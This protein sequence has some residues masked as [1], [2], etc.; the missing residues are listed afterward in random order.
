MATTA[1]LEYLIKVND[2]D[3]KELKSRVKETNQALGDETQ[4]SSSKFGTAMGSIAKG[5]AFAAGGAAIGGLAVAAKAGFGEFVEGQKVAAQTGAVLKSTGGAANV[6]A[7][8][9]EALAGTIS[10]KSGIDD[11]AIQ[12]GQNLLLTF[13]GI[14]N[15]AGKGNDIFN[16]AT[17][18]MTDMSVAMGTDASSQAIQLGKALNDPVK[19]ISA[20]T[21]V[22][23]TFTDAQK[24]QIKAMQEA[25]NTAG[26]QKVILAELQKEFGGSAEAAG[27][28]FGGQLNI[29]K[30]SLEGVA[31]E[32]IGKL[33]P[34]L[35]TFVGYL[36]NRVIPWLSNLKDNLTGSGGVKNAFGGVGD[37]LTNVFFP[38][39]R[40]IGT[41]FKDVFDAVLRTL[42]NNKEEIRTIV[43][44]IKTILEGIYIVI[45]EVVIPALK[46]IFKEGGPFDLVFGTAI[47]IVSGVITAVEKIVGGVRGA[48]NAVRDF[49]N[50]SGKEIWNGVWTAIKKPIDAVVGIVESI[51]NKVEW[52][53]DNLGKLKGKIPFI[54]DAVD[55]NFVAPDVGAVAAITGG[56]S[57][58]DPGLW[59]FLASARGMGLSLTSGY[60]PGAITA[61]GTP[62]DHGRFPSK[63]IDVSNGFNTPQMAAFFMSLIGN[64]RVKQAFYD[65]IGSIFG[66]RLSSYREGGHSDHVHVAT[67]HRGGIVPG[68]REVPALLMGGEGVFTRD[69]MRAMGGPAVVEAHLYLD[70]EEISYI[71]RD[72]I[73]RIG[74]NNVST[75][76]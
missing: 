39:I 72:K 33:V 66:G 38:T 64:P 55:P 3:L 48:I 75:G 71:I 59:G 76:V 29:L 8:Q 65:P 74:S 54:G 7:K 9:I 44:G 18:I 56:D 35:T 50:K 61:N 47:K 53:I 69:Q 70:G 49:W 41:L 68:N 30:N 63:A 43:N 12:S 6:T 45:R 28:T 27:K 51:V 42:N 10:R 73:A 58:I 36:T 26:A 5:A 13:T 11:E 1:T 2:R 19:G 67:Y 46:L 14:R 15:E 21:R 40:A 17:Q 22:G 24:E 32:V 20:L 57:T 31:G 60:R 52:L 23:V 34:H 62:S 16:Q 25:G 37:F 4:K